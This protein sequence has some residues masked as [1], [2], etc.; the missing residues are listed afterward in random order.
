MARKLA[1]LIGVS[2]Y[3]A[4]LPPV[5]T[6]AKDVDALYQ[7]LQNPQLGG[8]DSV[9]TLLDPDL[10]RMQ[11][12]I[13]KL[14]ANCKKDDLTLLFFSGHG[15]TD[16]RNGRLYLAT[17]ITSRDAFKATAV[18][19]GFIQDI[20]KASPSRQQVVIL[21]CCYSGAF[22]Q[23]WQAKSIS[24]CALLASSS[25]ISKSFEAEDSGVYTYY[26]VEGI[27][28]GTAD[29]DGNGVIS[30]DELHDYA[31]EKVQAVRE[32]M[33]PRI[34]TFKEGYKIAIA[35]ASICQTHSW[36]CVYTL[37]G[38]SDTVNCV[39]ISPD[40]K[41]LVSGSGD[42][43]I[44][45]WNPINGRLLDTLEGHSDTVNCVIISPDS[46]ILASGSVDKTIKI[47]NLNNR[48]LVRT[49]GGW[50]FTSGHIDAIRS[51][52]IT[53]DGKTLISGSQDHTI[54][55][56]NLATGGNIGNLDQNS[57]G[58]YSL[59]ITPDGQSI[60]SDCSDN[61]IKLYNL[62]K[63]ELIQELC[64]HSDWIWAIA[65]SPNGKILASGSQDKTVKLWN[66]STG[67]LLHTIDEHSQPIHAVAFSFDGQILASGSY[68]NTIKLWNVGTWTSI[69]TL[70]GHRNGVN[71]LAFSPDGRILASGSDDNT[72]K[73][74]QR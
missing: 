68:D 66:L 30:I 57:W 5:P 37:E 24:D 18:S 14:F 6:A 64:D 1:L 54:K 39:T 63:E 29:R 34:Q 40:S 16:D 10:V 12:A 36:R 53:P 62:D 41:I 48:Q 11:T 60:V 35:T 23:D 4:G 52:A 17:P 33:K 47:W 70:S 15:I 38:H 71:S 73:I 28:T 69:C 8:F 61:S 26:L 59:A 2:K 44:K 7:V 74:W 72:I 65:L 55:K 51:L 43:T 56:W 20:M 58:V 27:K 21:D 32:E 3:E 42:K 31:K 45:I 50:F 25:D 22:V 13:Q 9:E 67:E 19:A 49:V 46:K